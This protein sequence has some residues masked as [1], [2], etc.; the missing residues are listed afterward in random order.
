MIAASAHAAVNGVLD[1]LR[2]DG[3]AVLLVEQNTQRA[4]AFAD[5]VCVLESGWSVWAGTTAAA[6]NDAALV[7]AYPGMAAGDPA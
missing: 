6:R 7:Q 2:G 5:K 4:Q 3:L 1:R